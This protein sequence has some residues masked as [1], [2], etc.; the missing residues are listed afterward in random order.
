MKFK[1]IKK[2]K[3]RITFEISKASIAY[4]NTL[5]RVFMAEVPVMA[6]HN[7]EFKQNTSALYDELVAH[8]LGLLA[9]KTDLSTYNVP[10]VGEEPSAATHVVFTLKETGPKM[11]YA[12]DLKSK[13]PKVVPVFPETPIVKLIEN[14]E[15]EFVATAHLGFGKDHAKWNTGLVSYYYKPTITVNNKSAKMKDFIEKYP[16]QIRKKDVIEA[17]KINSPELIDAC[18]GIC[19]DIVKI[20]YESP[21]TDFVFTIES[22]GQLSPDSIVEEGL[23]QFDLQLDEFSKLVKELE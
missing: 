8:R 19:D 23:N 6:I 15:L 3:D 18:K 21:N 9:M 12:S 20:E 7:I 13:D 10:K 17:E 16:P 4:V 1:L 22:F 11:V 2:K 14:Q 5:R